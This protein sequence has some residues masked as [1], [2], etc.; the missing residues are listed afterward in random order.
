MKYQRNAKIFR[1]QLDAAPFVGVLFLLIIFLL[2]HTS[3]VFQPGIR[4]PLDLPAGGNWAGVSNPTM[5]VA[6]DRLGRIYYRNR[7]IST[8][9]LGVELRAAVKVYESGHE[10]LTLVV[11]A[12]KGVPYEVIVQLAA[13]AR[14]AGVHDWLQAVRPEAPAGNGNKTAP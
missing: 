8:N 5:A 9:E 3:F 7:V 1:G 10:S 4:A 14:S 13:L 2:L 12:D 11:Q 6:V